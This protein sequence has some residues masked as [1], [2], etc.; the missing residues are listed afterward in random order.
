MPVWKRSQEEFDSVTAS[1]NSG[2]V[3]YT[4]RSSNI[5]LILNR[6][7]KALILHCLNFG[8]T[9]HIRSELYFTCRSES[10]NPITCVLLWSQGR[11]MSEAKLKNNV[12]VWACVSVCTTVPVNPYPLQTRLISSSFFFYTNKFH[13]LKFVCMLFEG[14]N[15]Y[16]RLCHLFLLQGHYFSPYTFLYVLAFSICCTSLPSSCLSL[17]NIQGNSPQANLAY[18]ISHCG[19][20]VNYFEGEYW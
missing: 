1:P 4:C 3:T 7:W 2:P 6:F 18:F 13:L 17:L 9:Y 12:Y 16:D 15:D 8:S 11:K 19:L 20:A 10:A 5:S 14:F